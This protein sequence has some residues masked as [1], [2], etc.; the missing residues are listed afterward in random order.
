MD[1]SGLA[2][3]LAVLG[4]GLVVLAV[5]GLPGTQAARAEAELVQHRAVYAIGLAKTEAG[6]TAVTN[7]R[8]KLDF[9]WS[10]VCDGWAI[11]Q[12]TRIFVTHADGSQVDFGW[13]LNAWESKDGLT[14]R[15]FIR[16]LFGT[17]EEETVRGEARLD[18]PGLGG[19]A[20]FTEPE[21]R[22]ITLPKGTLFPSRHN[23]VI[24]EAAQ[25]ES[26]PVWRTVFD[27]S[28][29]DGG[30]YGVNVALARAFPAGAPTGLDLPLLGEQPSWRVVIAYFDPREDGVAPDYEQELRVFANGVIDELVLDY[31]DFSLDAELVDLEPLPAP[32]C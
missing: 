9:E 14:Y 22:T 2:R 26:L 32:D 23:F 4:C 12:R 7:A 29:E 24:V 16:R 20:T 15:F 19:T 31:G 21:E 8:G 18:G 25:N 1:S 17:G 6:G 10:D 30:Y 27:G 3:A 5:S 28:G 11:R 13:S